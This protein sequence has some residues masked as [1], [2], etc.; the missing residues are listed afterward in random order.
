[1][2][3][4]ERWIEW[5]LD[6]A[7]GVLEASYKGLAT[8][9]E[10][11]IKSLFPMWSTFDKVQKLCVANG[12]KQK[13]VDKTARSKDQGGPMTATERK[14]TVEAMWEQ[15]TVEK[16]WTKAAEGSGARGP[17]ASLIPLVKNAVGMGMT[18]EEIVQLT[19]KPLE[20]I[21]TIMEELAKNGEIPS[22]EEK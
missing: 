11:R 10:F 6:K 2:G 21:Q 9:S 13:L 7:E 20:Q 15:L 22:G 18:A 4:K 1:M 8:G 17:M 16:L 3:K 19:S 12:L 5:K 14:Q